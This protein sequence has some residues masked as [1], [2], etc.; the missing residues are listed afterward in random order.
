M[1]TARERGRF[2]T[3]RPE[4]K[5]RGCLRRRKSLAR[6]SAE[7]VSSVETV[8]VQRNGPHL[9]PIALRIDRELTQVKLQARVAATDRRLSIGARTSTDDSGCPM[10]KTWLFCRGPRRDTFAQRMPV[11]ATNHE[12]RRERSLIELSAARL[13]ETENC[14]LGHIETT[15]RL[16]PDDHITAQR[17]AATE[18]CRCTPSYFNVMS[19]LQSGT[20]LLSSG[21]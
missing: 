17:L 13:A 6:N 20:S 15:A 8:P 5:Q 16:R 7:T 1:C 11:C 19:R 18:I 21:L 4:A 2:D 3:V 12:T 14:G 10:R 9:G